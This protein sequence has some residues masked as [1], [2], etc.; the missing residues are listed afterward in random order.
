MMFLLLI[1]SCITFNSATAATHTPNPAEAICQQLA[2][3]C[4]DVFPHTS[5]RGAQHMLNVLFISWYRSKCNVQLS[6]HAH[7]AQ[8]ITEQLH[9]AHQR[10]RNP[11]H[12]LYQSHTVDF[13]QKALFLQNML[14]H[15]HFVANQYAYCV[16]HCLHS[17][18][19]ESATLQKLLADIRSQAR[20]YCMHRIG[21]IFIASM[22]SARDFYNTTF[23]NTTSSRLPECLSQLIDR[24]SMATFIEL[25]RTACKHETAV[26]Q[27][28]AMSHDLFNQC[29]VTL[30]TARADFYRTLYQNWYELMCYNGMSESAFLLCYDQNGF[31]DPL[32]QRYILPPPRCLSS[33]PDTFFSFE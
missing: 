12:H 25:D 16:E 19:L 8:D 4:C 17:A 28:L 13:A 26:A 2:Q 9:L 18:S 14:N 20:T 24:Y 32:D 22:E 27:H 5:A 1:L 3:R 6:M 15:Y 30:E 10:R 31:I 33:D 7:I 11:N 23:T 21:N 29:W